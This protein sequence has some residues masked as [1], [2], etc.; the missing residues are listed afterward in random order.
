VASKGQSGPRRLRY[1]FLLIPTTDWSLEVL[2]SRAAAQEKASGFGNLCNLVRR[3]VR[4]LCTITIFASDTMSKFRYWQAD[5]G[6][7]ALG[8]LTFSDG[9]AYRRAPST[10]FGVG[11]KKLR[12]NGTA[13]SACS[14]MARTR[15]SKTGTTTR[16]SPSSNAPYQAFPVR[17]PDDAIWTILNESGSLR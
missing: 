2:A 6:S 10:A 3:A 15:S 17:C 9:T 7:K 1:R 14:W 8:E 12:L 13:M 16:G 4:L 11:Q 5:F